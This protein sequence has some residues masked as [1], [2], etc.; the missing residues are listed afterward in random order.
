MVGAR[1]II[2][3][4]GGGSFLPGAHLVVDRCVMDGGGPCTVCTGGA[5]ARASRGVGGAVSSPQPPGATSIGNQQGRRRAAL[6]SSGRA[7]P[8]VLPATPERP[9]RQ[10]ADEYTQPGS[11]SGAELR[12]GIRE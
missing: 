10:E 11:C 4:G 1:E 3:G 12:A 8:P 9:T 5:L 6:V 7:A 2:F